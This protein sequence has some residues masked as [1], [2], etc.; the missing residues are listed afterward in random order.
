MKRNPYDRQWSKFRRT[1]L[2]ANPLCVMCREQG[3]AVAATVVDHIR[4]HR[5]D[6][7]L[8]W[9]LGNHQALCA[10]HHNSA[11]QMQE[12]RGYSSEI[13]RDGWP[14]DPQHPVLRAK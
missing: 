5:G 6:E 11:K 8:F 14:T 4:P 7:A 13:G 10:N 2:E 12:R 9:Q 3:H 1:F